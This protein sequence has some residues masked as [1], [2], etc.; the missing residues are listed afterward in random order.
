MK[1]CLNDPFQKGHGAPNQAVALQMTHQVCAN[2]S[3]MECVDSY[4]G[5]LQS[6]SQ[7]CSMHHIGQRLD[8]LAS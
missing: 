2:Y 7:S 8:L 3:R 5:V 6:P 4:A 1:G